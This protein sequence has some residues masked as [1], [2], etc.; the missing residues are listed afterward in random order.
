MQ[1]EQTQEIRVTTALTRAEYEALLSIARVE[2]RHPRLQLRALVI[3]EARRRELLPA[4]NIDR[5]TEEAAH[6]AR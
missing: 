2:L 1:I 4:E 3:E 6:A 5:A